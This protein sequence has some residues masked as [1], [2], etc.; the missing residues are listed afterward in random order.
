MRESDSAAD[1]SPSGEATKATIAKFSMAAIGFVGNIYFARVLGPEKIG[2]FYLFIAVAGFLGRPMTG[3]S[4][5]VRKR[6]SEAKTSIS[7][8]IGILGLF[9]LAWFLSVTAGTAV[10]HEQLVSYTGIASA[11]W[12]L[13]IYFG[14]EMLY[15][16]FVPVLQARGQVGFAY[17]MDALRS[18]VEIPVQFI[19]ITFGFGVPGLVA[20][21][22]SANLLVT[23]VVIRGLDSLPE[24]PDREL[25][26]RVVGFAKFS[27]PSAVIGTAYGKFDT[28]LLG[29][30]LSQAVVGD[31][32]VA[33]RLTAPAIF[34][35]SSVSATTLVRVSE[36]RSRGTDVST[37]VTNAL[38]FSSILAVPILFGGAV[39][40]SSLTKV[41]YGTAY[42]G[43][44]I[45]IG[46][47]GVQRVFESQT[48]ILLE[49]VNAID[50]PG[51]VFKLS[52]VALIVNVPLGVLLVREIGA[53]G[54][55]V[56]TI[57]VELFRYV[58]ARSLVAKEV[59]D[60]TLLTSTFLKQLLAGLVMATLVTLLES[61]VPSNRPIGLVVLLGVGAVVYSG[62]LL[63]ISTRVRS[64]TREVWTNTLH[65][66]GFHE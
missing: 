36:G 65:R 61:I 25:F 26:R 9:A 11:P 28:F 8:S 46:V 40:A 12:L 23:P 27:V 33:A 44:A 52:A 29:A 5:A 6:A 41:V 37:D 4:S 17:G 22:V 14:T 24:R 48:K 50:R 32:G 10:F 54:V 21:L 2:G 38:A 30:L 18:Y 58:G 31:Y 16:T 55:V 20:G 19:L 59:P 66:F 57:S 51:Y 62:T 15:G 42:T 60:A 39:I 13:V 56:A 43:A 34:V 63:L 53:I 49:V 45:F 47:L 7:Q 64:T 35:A 1:I 3:I